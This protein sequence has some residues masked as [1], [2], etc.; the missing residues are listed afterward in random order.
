MPYSCPSKA[1]KKYMTTRG[2]GKLRLS[3][4][5]IRGKLMKLKMYK[6]MDE[7][8]EDPQNYA[9]VHQAVCSFTGNIRKT[10]FSVLIVTQRE[11]QQ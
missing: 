2:H 5:K 7:F 9:K 4:Y 10:P 6:L 11:M 3:Q 8:F 1:L